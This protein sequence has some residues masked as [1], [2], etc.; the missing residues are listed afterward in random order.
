LKKVKTTVKPV[1]T[2]PPWEQ[3]LWLE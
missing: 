1:Y 2:E 3:F